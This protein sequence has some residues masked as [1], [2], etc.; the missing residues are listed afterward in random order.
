LKTFRTAFITG[1]L[2]L[3]PLMATVDILRWFMSAVDTAVRQYIPNYI[4]QVDF[5]GF[6]LLLAL[7]LI[8]IIGLLTQNFVGQWLVQLLDMGMRKLPVVGGLYSGLK[9]FLETILN[10][11]SGKFNGVVLIQFPRAG[12]H[13]IGFRTGKPDPKLA[14]YGKNLVNVFVPCT[15]NPTSGFYLLVAE[16]EL[17]PLQL[18]VQEAFR[19]VVSMGIVTSDE[20]LNSAGAPISK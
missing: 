1:L 7:V 8:F 17:I 11:S 20:V 19:L 10:P 6:G 14:S 16:E 5:P 18:S 15:P 2:I 3:V 4:L 12:I 13:S 9:K